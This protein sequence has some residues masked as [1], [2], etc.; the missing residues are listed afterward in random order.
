MKKKILS[1]VLTLILI[2]P[3]AFGFTACANRNSGNGPS[4]SAK[5]TGIEVIVKDNFDSPN[6]YSCVYD[7]VIGNKEACTMDE[8]KVYYTYSDGKRKE[9]KKD[10]YNY[11]K[12]IDGAFYSPTPFQFMLSGESSD[13]APGKHI[14]RFYSN[15]GK[16]TA[17]LV[18]EIFKTDRPAELLDFNINQYTDYANTTYETTKIT[19]ENDVFEI[20]FAQDKFSDFPYFFTASGENLN[21][22]NSIE[23]IVINDCEDFYSSEN[24][25]LYALKN[26]VGYCNGTSFTDIEGNPLKPGNY[27]VFA[28]YTA[29]VH[30]NDGISAPAKIK[31]MPKYV[32]VASSA[33]SMP[34]EMDL[35]VFQDSH[36]FSG[37]VFDFNSATQSIPFKLEEVETSN[38]LHYVMVNYFDG[39]SWKSTYWRNLHNKPIMVHA[40]KSS[41]DKYYLTD[42]V[43]GEWYKYGTTT[44]VSASSINFIE[45]NKLEDYN[46]NKTLQTSLFLSIN[47][48]EINED[49]KT[50]LPYYEDINN[51]F[52]INLNIIP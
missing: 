32:N 45:Y 10:E 33:S 14:M 44:K 5:I 1:L 22:E 2:L 15:T 18:V 46:P 7:R 47:L 25:F 19:G 37:L 11:K 4:A 17:D 26:K 42:Y 9:L 48:N 30:F 20:E 24:H 3:C 36:L 43:D 49:E 50:L 12:Y 27:L 41:D 16:F 39:Q 23:F 13:S 51:V 38:Y 52:R 34:N 28:H 8:I 29:T 31:I 6:Y 21:Y 40:Y 35:E